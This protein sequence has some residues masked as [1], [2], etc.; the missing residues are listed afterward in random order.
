[1]LVPVIIYI[2]V[3]LTMAISASLRKGSVSTFSYNLILLGALLFV[4]SDSFLA[5][6]KFYIKVPSEHIII[7]STYAFAQYCIVMGIL[8]QKK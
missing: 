6:N 3:I 1:M 4:I 2:L 8:K 5:I 7:M